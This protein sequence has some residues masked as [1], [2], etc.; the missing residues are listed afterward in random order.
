MTTYARRAALGLLASALIS[1]VAAPAFAQVEIIERAPLA[2]IVE[3]IP[4]LPRPGMHWVPGH[5]AWRG[6]RWFWIRGHYV[7]YDVPAMPALIVETP[8]PSPGPKFFWVRGH[9]VWEGRGWV[10]HKGHWYR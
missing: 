6:A 5:Y 7:A 9:Y 4:P 8:P 2:P 10:W 3:V 1:A